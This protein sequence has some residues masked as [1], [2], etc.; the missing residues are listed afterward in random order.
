MTR[1]R[2]KILPGDTH[3]YFITATIVNWLPLFSNPVIASLLFDSLKFMAHQSIDYYL[4][5]GNRFILD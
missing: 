4:A 3:P 2:Y 1:T 5:Q